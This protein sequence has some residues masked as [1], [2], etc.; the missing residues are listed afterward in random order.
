MARSKGLQISAKTGQALKDCSG[1]CGP[2]DLV[3][4][5]L[6]LGLRAQHL[7]EHIVDAVGGRGHRRLAVVRAATADLQLYI[8]KVR[9]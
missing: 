9:R 4:A 1:G 2:A 6:R 7:Q 8:E 3:L 5:G